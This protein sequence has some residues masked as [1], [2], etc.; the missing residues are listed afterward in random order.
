MGFHQFRDFAGAF[1]AF[2][3]MSWPIPYFEEFLGKKFWYKLGVKES[4]RIG[5]P[6]ATV[7]AF[8]TDHGGKRAV[9]F[10]T[11]VVEGGREEEDVVSN[12]RCQRRQLRIAVTP[13]LARRRR[14]PH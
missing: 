1:H 10:R 14:P 12:D 13:P 7:I 8:T 2:A 5:E 6:A 4:L 3:M 11:S 9:Q